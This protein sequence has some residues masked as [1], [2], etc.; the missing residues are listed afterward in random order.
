MTVPDDAAMAQIASLRTMPQQ[1]RGKDKL[2][3]MIDAADRIMA[4]EGADAITTTRIAT[5]A[6][7]SVGSVYRYLPHRGAIIETLAQHYLGLLED[8]L[9]LL[10]AGL[11]SGSWGQ[12]D[13][14]GEAVDAFAEF[15]RAH[16]G[17]RALWFG[18]HLT[19]ETQELDRAHKLTM[20]TRLKTVLVAREIGR[21]DPWTLRV[22]QVIQLSTD[23]VI[24]E[25]FRA[26]PNGDDALLDQLKTMIRGY[27]AELAPQE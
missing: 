3:R 21:D 19:A 23:A 1:A 7:I 4:S 15:Y 12:V 5:E 25:A 9:E 24:Q 13:L 27:L 8:Q 26:D 6:G 11:E 20:A 16:P 2:A 17:F 22:S 18:R 10:I 14:V